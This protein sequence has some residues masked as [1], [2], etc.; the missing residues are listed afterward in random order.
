MKLA[1]ALIVCATMA[2]MP[3]ASAQKWELGGGVGGG[4]YTSQDVTAP[5]ESA[6]AKIQS[7]IS[8]SAWF[9]NNGPGKWA[10]EVRYDYQAGDLQLSSGGTQATFAANTQAVH[11]DFLYHFSKAE[12]RIR[13]FVAAGAGI[14]IYRGTGTQVVYQPLSNLALLS[15]DQDLTPLISVGAGVKVKLAS[16]LQIRLDVHDY[17]TTFP[18]QVIAPAPGAK[19]G[20]W[21]QDFVPLAGLAYLF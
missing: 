6:E 8:G 2:A 16:H 4:F 11:F 5:G 21:L 17:L 15:Q 14:K 7:S 1:R 12:A 13:P 20:G 19:V 18:K 3:Q 10:G 9:A